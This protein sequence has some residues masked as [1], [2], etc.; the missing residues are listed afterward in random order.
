MWSARLGSGSFSRRT[1]GS[2][3]SPAAAGLP[4]FS[5]TASY[6]CPTIM[7][8]ENRRCITIWM[9]FRTF[10]AIFFPDRFPRRF[11]QSYTGIIHVYYHEIAF[12]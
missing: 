6:S 8:V 5:A 4:R 10:M 12:H 2:F 11:V 3:S 7:I 9:S 1:A